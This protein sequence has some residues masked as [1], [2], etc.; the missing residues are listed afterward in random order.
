ME[1]QA[2]H[3]AVRA[4]RLPQRQEMPDQ[5]QRYGCSSACQ[6]VSRPENTLSGS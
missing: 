2:A 1:N 3:C 5:M 4:G 6:A